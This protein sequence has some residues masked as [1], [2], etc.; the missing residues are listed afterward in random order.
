MKLL[1]EAAKLNRKGNSL[2][3]ILSFFFLA[4]GTAEEKSTTGLYR[5]LLYQLFEK[6]VDLRDSLDWMTPDGAR[7]IQR[8]GWHEEAL[9][10]HWRM[11]FRSL[12]V[13]C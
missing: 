3:L 9:S 10:R 4:R 13:A 8:N 11:L 7:G 6:V 1:F 5:S 12:E 2:E